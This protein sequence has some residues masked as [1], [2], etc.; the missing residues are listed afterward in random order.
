[1]VQS[2]PHLTPVTKMLLIYI[3]RT[4]IIALQWFSCY[5]PSHPATVWHHCPQTLWNICGVCVFK[6]MGKSLPSNLEVTV[7]KQLFTGLAGFT[8]EWLFLEENYIHT[9]SNALLHEARLIVGD[10]KH[11]WIYVVHN[12]AL[13]T[14]IIHLQS[15]K[16]IK[17]ILPKSRK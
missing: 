2:S 9:H 13:N 5:K 17:T 15:I 7:N 3:T 8:Y 6:V 14:Y 1:M 10:V 11:W 16:T 12:K 4:A